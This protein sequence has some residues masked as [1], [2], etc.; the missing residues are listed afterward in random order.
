MR[1]IPQ[2][3]DAKSDN[4]AFVSLA[5]Y[6]VTSY[7]EV[8]SEDV[9]TSHELAARWIE[10]L[11]EHLDLLTPFAKG[12][13]AYSYMRLGNPKRAKEVLEL[14]M[15]GARED[16]IAGVYWTPEKYSW[17]WYSDTVEKHAFLLRA[18]QKISPEDRR[19]PGMVR[20]LLF[21]RKGTVW[22]STKASA[23]A[24]YAILDCASQRGALDSDEAFRAYWGERTHTVVAKADEW[25][26]EPYRWQEKGADISPDMASA[27][28]EKRGPGVAFASMTWTYS[29]DEVPA[30]SEPGMLD[31]E[32][33]FYRR[34][35]QADAYHLVPLDSGE[36]VRV[37][38][39]VEVQLKLNTRAQFEYIHLM[40]PKA[41]GFEAEVLTSGWKYDAL[42]F[43][44]EPRASLTNF[45]V[46]WLPHGEYILRYRLR[47]T[48]P[49]TYRVGAAT[50]QSMYAP[51]MTAHSSGF[52]INVVK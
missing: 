37:G 1:E 49:G 22:K 42:S 41:A 43:Y 48:K 40:D 7:D 26:P 52:V 13:L 46:S 2:R 35:R 28:I 25:R 34:V 51:E 15:D 17:V 10:I 27:R 12:R 16:P 36:E 44:E 19:I 9:T 3:L 32:R 11:E 4:L 29:T 5:V 47:P 23:A 50:L 20:W 24:V 39:Q 45:F 38:D 6:V 33:K 30:A 8:V 18:L 31:L 21:S 14:A